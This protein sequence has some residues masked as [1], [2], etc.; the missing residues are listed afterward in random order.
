MLWIKFYGVY[1]SSWPVAAF[2][3]DLGLATNGIQSS[4]NHIYGGSL[5]LVFCTQSTAAV[6]LQEG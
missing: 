3:E 2:S 1:D 6:P 5:Q 4:Q